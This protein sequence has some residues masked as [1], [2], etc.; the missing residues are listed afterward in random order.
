MT[1]RLSGLFIYPVKSAR[2]ISLSEA[3]LTPRGLAHDRRFMIVDGAGHFV[4]QRQ[5]PQL[6]RLVPE[7]ADHRLLLGFDSLTKLSVPLQPT[8]GAPLR[9]TV[10]RDQV[11]AMDCGDEAANLCAAILGQPARLVYMPDSSLRQ[12]SLSYA[13]EGDV[14][15]FADGFPYLLTNQ[16]SLDE[17]NSRLEEKV[18]MSRFRPNLVVEGA[19]AYAE[20]G[21]SR[22]QVG[23]VPFDVRKPCDRCVIITTDQLSGERVGK[24]PLKTLAGYHT[25][26]GKSAF[27]QNL[28]AR[29]PGT[30]RVG[31]PVRLLA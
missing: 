12:V 11:D 20:D 16:G 6:A 7:L 15:S 19:S 29:A 23:D 1:L 31:D 4:T 9:V 26:N 28:L 18:P 24:E 5:A 2:G 17:L 13:A 3:L 14:V 8:A 27:G 10:W 22:L 21:W 25:W 30:L